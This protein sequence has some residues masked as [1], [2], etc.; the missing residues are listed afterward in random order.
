MKKNLTLIIFL[1]IVLVFL[2]IGATQTNENSYTKLLECM[3]DEHRIGGF[4]EAVNHTLG[5]EVKTFNEYIT[6]FN[7]SCASISYR[8]GE[9]VRAEAQ[10]NQEGVENLREQG[11]KKLR[12]ARRNRINNT[13]HVKS[14]QAEIKSNPFPQ[15]ATLDSPRQWEDVQITGRKKDGFWEI[16]WNNPGL[17]TIAKYGWILGGFLEKG[18]GRNARELHCDKI[19]G[20]LPRNGEIIRM[21][22]HQNGKHQLIVENGTSMDAYVKIITNNSVA[23]SFL[24]NSKQSAVINNMGNGIFQVWSIFGKKYSR[25]C[26]SFSLPEYANKFVESLSYDPLQIMTYT[27]TLHPVIDGKARTVT[28]SL[29]EFENL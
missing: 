9:E 13:Y 25:G 19:A 2:N 18:Y 12:D 24:V 23:K 21:K 27:L 16:E 5:W 8:I 29:S 6:R 17:T 10:I 11:R 3:R 20:E 7:K 28:V 14:N 15:S 4:R 26:D 22:Q 1:N